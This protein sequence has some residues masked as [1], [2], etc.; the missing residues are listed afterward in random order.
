MKNVFILPVRP[1]LLQK[2]LLNKRKQFTRINFTFK[3]CV[4]VRRQ[5]T[6]AHRTNSVSYIYSNERRWEKK[7]S[8][9][10]DVC[11]EFK[12]CSNKWIVGG[13]GVSCSRARQHQIGSAILFPS[14]RFS[15]IEPAFTVFP[16]GM[17]VHVTSEQNALCACNCVCLACKQAPRTYFSYNIFDTAVVCV[18]R[19]LFGARLLY[20]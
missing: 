4:S 5:H 3:H 10:N 2:R 11:M 7:K 8:K 15:R 16:F 6:R 12:F 14:I 17:P 1:T 18:F 9:M 19:K 20:V 13:S